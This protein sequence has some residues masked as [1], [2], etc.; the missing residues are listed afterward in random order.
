MSD[1]YVSVNVG[2]IDYPFTN[3]HLAPGY[4]AGSVS[5][6]RLGVRA[7]LLGHEFNRYL[8]AQLA[9]FRP[10]QL[11]WYR[12]LNGA[13]DGHHVRVAFGGGSLRPQWP[14]SRRVS[15]YGEI[16]IGVTSRAGFEAGGVPV[17]KS[18]NI[19]S[20]FYGGGMDLH[21]NPRWDLVGSVTVVPG[22]DGAHQPRAVFV[23]GGFKYIMRPLPP[24]RV[25]A[26][27]DGAYFFPVHQMQV[28]LTSGV[29]YGLNTFVTKT[30]PV[31]WG[32][33]VNVDRGIAAHYSRNIFHSRRLFSFDTGVSAGFWQSQAN[34]ARF[35]TLSLYPLLRLTF[36][37]TARADVFFEYSLAGPTMIS[38]RVIDGQQTGER[39]TFQDF[40]GIGAFVGPRRNVRIGIKVGHYSNGNLFAANP[41][42]NVPL[43]FSLGYGF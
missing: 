18:L 8:S 11:V 34:H 24:D 9:Y 41:G 29:A 33:D 27:R 3:R 43:T 31:F 38:R 42:V 36:I 26:N 37:R 30:V 17:V 2:F 28:E 39:F 14:V 21:V 5:I 22:S 35:V 19:G 23:S 16:G 7:V 15:L 10:V 4:T 40:M 32:G 12:N 6:P 25:A 20:A 13:P 1:S